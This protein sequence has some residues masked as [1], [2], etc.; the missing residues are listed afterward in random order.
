MLKLFLIFAQL[1]L[2]T[3]LF[4]ENKHNEF[5]TMLFIVILEYGFLIKPHRKRYL[6]MLFEDFI[7]KFD[8]SD[9]DY[10]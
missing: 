2:K 5:F 4:L 10:I 1:G 6:K 7:K 3:F 9:E 8:M